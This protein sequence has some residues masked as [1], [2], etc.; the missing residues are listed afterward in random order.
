MINFA[1]K[2]FDLEETIRCSFSLTKAEFKIFKF[3]MKN[4]TKRFESKELAKELHLELSTVQRSM[5]KMSE[6]GII[7]RSK[8]NLENAGYTYSY[9]ICEKYK[10]KNK[11]KEI[12]QSQTNKFEEEIEKW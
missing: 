7:I 6:N 10:I 9:C 1:C 5:K 8:V 11:V 2:Q 3:L 4:N 12:I